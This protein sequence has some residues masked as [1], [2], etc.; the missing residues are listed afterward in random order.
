MRPGS[1]WRVARRCLLPA[2]PSSV[3]EADV[4]IRVTGSKKITSPTNGGT[5]TV[6]STPETG[7]VIASTNPTKFLS[8]EPLP[9]LV[10]DGE[11]NTGEI[12]HLR[13]LCGGVQAIFR[14]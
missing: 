10:Y 13:G 5:H 1:K 11:N 9:F 6:V 2:F 4:K 12:A 8:G 3:Q 7:N 14:V